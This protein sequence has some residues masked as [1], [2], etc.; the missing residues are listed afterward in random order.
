MFTINPQQKANLQPKVAAITAQISISKRHTYASGFKIPLLVLSFL[1]SSASLGQ[2]EVQA[3]DSTVPIQGQNDDTAQMVT[4]SEGED[5]E[6]TAVDRMYARTTDLIQGTTGH[7]DSFFSLDTEDAFTGNDTKVRLRLNTDYIEGHGWDLHP[8]FRLNLALPFLSNKARFVMNE[9]TDED[10]GSASSDSGEGSDLA[11]R[12]VELDG[13]TLG[14]SFDLGLRISGVGYPDRKTEPAGFARINTS[15]EFDLG[16]WS[17]RTNNRLYYYSNTGTRNDFRQYFDRSINDNLMFR[18]RTRIQYFEENGYNPQW[19]QK[20]SVFHKINDKNAIVYEAVVGR[21]PIED[22][23]F[24]P[25]EIEVG[26]QESYYEG[27]I[28]IRYR[29]NIWRPWLYVEAWPV[30]LFPEEKDYKASPAFRIRLEINFG[31][32]SSSERQIDE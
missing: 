28:R 15:L 14:L 12:W 16:N 8:N 1:M 17:S 26:L 25:D 18:S 10:Q 22:S 23:V 32:E 20:L 30:L 7:F 13:D 29:R 11:L 4:N 24:D 9:D 19:E 2:E 3:T 21:N 6:A 5:V 31:A 27:Q